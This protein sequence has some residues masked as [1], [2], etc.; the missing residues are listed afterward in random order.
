MERFPAP[1]CRM[2][3]ALPTAAQ[4]DP[5]RAVA[6]QGAP[7]ANSHLAAL[8]AHP[9]CAPLPCF[10][11]ADAIEAVQSGAAGRAIIPIEI[12]SMAASP[13]FISCCRNRGWR[14]R[15]NSS[16]RSATH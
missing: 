8:Q 1:A 16:C 10:D 5:A 14:S 11:F 9:G 7:G 2:S 3:R 15:A 12:R 6:F 13:T 4:A